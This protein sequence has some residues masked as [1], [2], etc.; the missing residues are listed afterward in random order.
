MMCHANKGQLVVYY[1]ADIRH[2]YEI[3]LHKSMEMTHQ[4]FQSAR[5]GLDHQTHSIACCI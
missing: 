5:L 3:N 2:N 1:I 4:E